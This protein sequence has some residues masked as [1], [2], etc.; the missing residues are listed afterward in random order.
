MKKP[1]VILPATQ[2]GDVDTFLDTLIAIAQRI[3]EA[4]AE[5][6]PNAPVQ[7]EQEEDAEP[8]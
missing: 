4:K 3:A 8:A 6:T 5:K 1:P 7:S 2:E